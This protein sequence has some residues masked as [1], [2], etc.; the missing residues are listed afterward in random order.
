MKMNERKKWCKKK[1]TEEKKTYSEVKDNIYECNLQK[2]VRSAASDVW[3]SFSGCWVKLDAMVITVRFDSSN[4]NTKKK[5]KKNLQVLTHFLIDFHDGGLIR[6]AIAIVWSGEY[7]DSVSVVAP[8]VTLITVET[9]T[10]RSSGKQ[11]RVQ[12]P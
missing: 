1:K 2:V 5:K 10:E 4:R 12:P 7:G 3:L 9:S 6:A 11:K 8:V